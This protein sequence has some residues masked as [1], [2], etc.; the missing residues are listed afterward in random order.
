MTRSRSKILSVLA[1]ACCK[2]V[3]CCFLKAFVGFF[4][5]DL[6]ILFEPKF[7]L[8]DSLSQNTWKYTHQCLLASVFQASV[9]AVWSL[10]HPVHAAKRKWAGRSPQSGRS[11]ELRRQEQPAWEN[12]GPVWQCEWHLILVAPCRSCHPLRLLRAWFQDACRKAGA[13]SIEKR[14]QEGNNDSKGDMW[15]GQGTRQPLSMWE[16]WRQAAWQCGSQGAGLLKSAFR[17]AGCTKSGCLRTSG[18]CMVGSAAVFVL[19]PRSPQLLPA[20]ASGQPAAELGLSGSNLSWEGFAW[21]IPMLLAQTCWDVRL[22]EAPAFSFPLSFY[23]CQTCQSWGLSPLTW[24]F[25]SHFFCDR[26]FPR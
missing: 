1:T 14:Y 25:P 9:F 21:G 18:S 19:R 3:Q 20:R 8:C 11:V 24:T 26:L 13:W 15:Q 16:A 12:R 7:F 4:A 23:R 5:A 2:Q 6:E 10:F 22:F 17:G